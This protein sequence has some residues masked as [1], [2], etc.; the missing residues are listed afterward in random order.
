[1]D[2]RDGELQIVQQEGSEKLQQ[3]P[4]PPGAPAPSAAALAAAACSC[5][6]AAQLGQL[7]SCQVSLLGSLLPPRCR[8]FLPLRPGIAT[9]LAVVV[10]GSWGGAACSQALSLLPRSQCTPS[11]KLPWHASDMHPPR[12]VRCV[13]GAQREHPEP[14]HCTLLTS[15]SSLQATVRVTSDSSRISGPPRHLPHGICKRRERFASAS[16]MDYGACS[17]ATEFTHATVLRVATW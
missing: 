5:H 9:I 12:A 1:M 4:T 8:A 17:G 11:P 16:S 3:P 14:L 2:R 7:C 10:G 6:A 15:V 13:D